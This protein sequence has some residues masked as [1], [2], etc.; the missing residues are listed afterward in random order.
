MNIIELI[1][2]VILPLI[3][4][5]FMV[6]GAYKKVN[7]YDEFICGVKDSLITVYNIFPAVVVLM[8][9]IGMF[10]S[11]GLLEILTGLLR[12]FFNYINIPEEVLSVAILRP[13]SGSGGMAMLADIIKNCG[14]DSKAGIIASV[15]CGST[16]TTFYTVAVYFGA[17]GI[18]DTRHTIKCALIADAVSI[19]SGIAICNFMLF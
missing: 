11:S 7:I 3:F 8:M 4:L 5:V 12:P 14:P 18:T 16:E 10:R 9:A 17:V 19:I 6:Y 1:S 2:A 13:M 15:I